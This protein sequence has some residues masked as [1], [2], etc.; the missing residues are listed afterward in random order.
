MIPQEFYTVK[1]NLIT[2]TKLKSSLYHTLRFDRFDSSHVDYDPTLFLLSRINDS[3]NYKAFKDSIVVDVRQRGG[4]LK[5]R[6]TDRDIQRISRDALS[7]WDIGHWDGKPYQENGVV[8]IR[9]SD[10][11]LEGKS[12]EQVLAEIEEVVNKYKAY[13][14][15]AFIEF[16]SESSNYERSIIRN[17]EFLGGEH[18]GYFFAEDSYGNYE[19]VKE[20]LGGYDD[21]MLKLDGVS[22][23]VIRIPGH[24]FTVGEDYE[25]LAKARRASGSPNRNAYQ[26]EI[27][28]MDGT[29]DTSRSTSIAYVTT[30][31]IYTVR[32]TAE[33]KI[34]Y[35]NIILG[36]D[37]TG[38]E[39]DVYY[40]D[41]MI[42]KPVGM[43]TS[44]YHIHDKQ[45]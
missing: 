10:K 33:K 24:Q 34:K 15:H 25:V 42:A 20:E 44:N 8:L 27:V 29:K 4:G 23:Y 45:N 6:V 14:I 41:Y 43:L 36:A 31:G 1:G 37:K 35:V 32:F 22:Q 19:I 7:N 28:Y 13:G 16:Y 3:F 2:K 11:V 9:V 30:W 26:I 17:H 18:C 39:E 5:R 38:K 40:Y 21:Y 12:E